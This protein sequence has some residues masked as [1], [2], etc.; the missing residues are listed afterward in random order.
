MTSVY[1]DACCLN[2]PF[3]DQSQDR[4]RVESEAVL[5]VLSHLVA[6]EWRWV[7]SEV[8]E[9]EIERDPDYD[10]CQRVRMIASHA[11]DQVQVDGQILDR[12]RT[13]ETLGFQAY[14]ALHVACAE[15]GSADVLLTTDD[16]FVR[17]AIRHVAALGVR[18]EN[19][20]V[21]LQEVIGQ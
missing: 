6:D 17:C 7:S 16:R 5:I 9:L 21:W 12:A 3:D 18:V 19:P 4:I 2:R 10:R 15:A 1:L 8:L 13:L 20:L 14:D 11:P